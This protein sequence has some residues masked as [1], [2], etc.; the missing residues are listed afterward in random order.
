L[1][2]TRHQKVDCDKWYIRNG[3]NSGRILVLHL[4][5]YGEATFDKH[6]VILITTATATKKWAVGLIETSHILY[7]TAARKASAA[8]LE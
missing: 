8:R 1:E 7:A 4:A 6:G 3:S 5:N 2:N